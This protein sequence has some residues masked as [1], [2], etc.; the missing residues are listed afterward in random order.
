V[1]KVH[2]RIPKQNIK[3]LHYDDDGDNNEKSFNKICKMCCDFS[4][5]IVW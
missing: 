2:K 3:S 4:C 1:K 5:F